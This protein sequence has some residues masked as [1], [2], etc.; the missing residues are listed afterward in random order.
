MAGYFL[1]L[2]RRESNQ[3][4]RHPKRLGLQLTSMDGGNANLSGAFI[5]TSTSGSPTLKYTR[6]KAPG[7]GFFWFVFFLKENELAGQG[8]TISQMEFKCQKLPGV[9]KERL[10]KI[11]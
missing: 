9:N 11:I 4:E 8:E 5:A 10:T 3:R 2:A 7:E 1:L 6:A